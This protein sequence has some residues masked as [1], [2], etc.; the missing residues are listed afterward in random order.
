LSRNYTQQSEEKLLELFY[1]NEHANDL[2]SFEIIKHLEDEEFSISMLISLIL[3]TKSPAFKKDVYKYICENFPEKYH[4]GFRLV[5]LKRYI[6]SAIQHLVSLLKPAF[7]KLE[8]LEFFY[9]IIKRRGKGHDVFLIVDNGE[10][11]VV[12]V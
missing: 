11:W 6:P 7:S 4:L 12:S 3:A 2:L 8:I 1:S 9:R 10:H 5:A